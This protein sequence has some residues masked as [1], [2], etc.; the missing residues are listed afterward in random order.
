M[1]PQLS[2]FYF[3]TA[4]YRFDI[5]PFAEVPIISAGAFLET[6]EVV[7]AHRSRVRTSIACLA[8][9]SRHLKCDA[10]DPICSR[11]ELD[12]T[13][14]RY[15]KSKRGGSG[16]NRTGAIRK[17][18]EKATARQHHPEVMDF[19]ATSVG[20][21][22]FK[23][24]ESG[25]WSTGT[26]GTGPMS[27]GESNGQIQVLLGLYYE[28]F[29]DAHPIALPRWRLN[30]FLEA[31]PESLKCLLPVLGYIGSV[32]TTSIS[33]D[34]LRKNACDVLDSGALLSNPFVVQALLL[35]SIAIHCFDDYETARRYID[36]AIDIAL[37]IQMNLRQFA[38]ENSQWDPVVKESLRRTWWSL[39]CTD[40][41]FAF[42][43]HQSTHRLYGIATDVDLPCEN[44][45]YEK[46][47]RNIN[48]PKSPD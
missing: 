2:Q 4:D 32:Y 26:L 7:K 47:V 8:C 9:R 18:S 3:D 41:L 10:R 16:P 19:G 43:C 14:C 24:P 21:G 17:R 48:P 46:G 38:S 37:S 20:S 11:C 45:D 35:F 28:N 44:E 6:H 36:R 5:L 30:Q 12:G 29:H 15:T 31:D 23:T 1:E 25:T 13:P 33:S 42:I 40:T 22:V 39:F 27:L 34:Q